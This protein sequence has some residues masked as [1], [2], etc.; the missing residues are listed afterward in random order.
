MWVWSIYCLFFHSKIW[1]DIY[2]FANQKKLVIWSNFRANILINGLFQREL[3]ILRK[4]VVSCDVKGQL[5]RIVIVRHKILGLR[6]FLFNYSYFSFTLCLNY[7]I[8]W[9][10]N[11]TVTMRLLIHAYQF[12]VSKLDPSLQDT[13]IIISTELGNVWRTGT[14]C[15]DSLEWYIIIC[16]CP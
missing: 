11:A 7:F 4:L 3:P 6:L 13:D 14:F 1:N 10:K 2:R 9:I 5:Y 15:Q 12:L 8:M 16:I